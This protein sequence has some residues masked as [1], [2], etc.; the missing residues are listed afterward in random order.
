[1]RRRPPAP[2]PGHA[3][4]SA[5][6]DQP[7]AAAAGRGQG[8]R[9]ARQVAAGRVRGRGRV[10]HR[11][12]RPERAAAPFE[13]AAQGHLSGQEHLPHQDPPLRAIEAGRPPCRRLVRGRF[14][15]SRPRNL[16]V[17]AGVVGFARSRRP[18]LR[19][20]RAP[21]PRH[22]QP[23]Q[24]PGRQSPGHGQSAHGCAASRTAGA[25]RGRGS[26]DPRRPR[27]LHP[28]EH[29]FRPLQPLSRSEP[30]D[31]VAKT[32][33]H[34]ADRGRG[35]ASA[36]MVRSRARDVRFLC[37]DATGP[38]DGVPRPAHRRAAASGREPRPLAQRNRRARQRRGDP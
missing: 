17:R 16:S 27:A 9:A 2:E 14:G 4:D 33:W 13:T 37:R 29:Q 32:A 12:R 18:L 20:G 1:M 21:A 11:A 23:R 30:H 31:H 28:G 26:G 24:R 10:Q 6:R 35:S 22:R 25:L 19:L 15:L 38:G 34:R 3:R 8:A 7:L 36:G 5:K